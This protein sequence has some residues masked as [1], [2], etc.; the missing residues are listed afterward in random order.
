MCKQEPPESPPP[1]KIRADDF[2]YSV[3]LE[4]YAQ[5]QYRALSAFRPWGKR[6][7]NLLHPERVVR[8]AD[9]ARFETDFQ[10]NVAL[11]PITPPV[12]DVTSS[13]SPPPHAAARLADEEA[14]LSE[15][16][17]R[18]D[19]RE[20][21]LTRREARLEEREELVAKREREVERRRS[22]EQPRPASSPASDEPP[23]APC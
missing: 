19:E 8:I 4:Q 14:R 22:E 15:I 23:P 13:T 1:K 11:K 3:Y 10:P 5:L 7:P 2:G 12:D 21:E 18:L 20:R 16:A 9:C 6:E 17:R